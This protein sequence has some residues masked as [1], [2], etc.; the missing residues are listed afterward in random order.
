MTSATVA[1]FATQCLFFAAPV[2]LGGFTHIAVI[3]LDLFPRLARIPL[4]AG[5][6]IGGARVFGDNKTLR[7]ALAMIGASALWSFVLAALV[8]AGVV[9]TGAQLEH[10]LLW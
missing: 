2:I 8:P 7:G 1:T 3:K 6:E 10:P 4:D 5:I 9:V